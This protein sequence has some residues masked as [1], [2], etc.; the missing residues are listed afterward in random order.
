MSNASSAANTEERTNGRTGGRVNHQTFV[1]RGGQNWRILARSILSARAKRSAKAEAHTHR[2]PPAT[3][4]ALSERASNRERP[5]PPAAHIPF[6]R[7]AV[8]RNAL[9][10]LAPLHENDQ[11]IWVEFCCAAFGARFVPLLRFCVVFVRRR[12]Q[13]CAVRRVPLARCCCGC[14]PLATRAPNWKQ[15]QN[16]EKKRLRASR[17]LRSKISR[18]LAIAHSRLNTLLANKNENIHTHTQRHTQ[19]SQESN[20]SQVPQVTEHLISSV[21]PTTAT[22]CACHFL[23]SAG[24]VVPRSGTVCWRKI[25]AIQS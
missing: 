4:Q 22:T 16:K 11:L 13:Q 21:I 18:W 8:Q 10:M 20:S 19:P 7:C 12:P 2:P 15:Q 6:L 9:L 17:S 25:L 14:S 3:Q 5:P 1:A 24:P 23:P